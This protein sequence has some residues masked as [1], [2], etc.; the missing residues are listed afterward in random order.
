MTSF[1]G[2]F[3][4]M[5]RANGVP[6]MITGTA[7]LR[8]GANFVLVIIITD[9]TVTAISTSEGTVF[10]AETAIGAYLRINSVF[11]IKG[12]L[13]ATSA[14]FQATSLN[15]QYGKGNYLDQEDC[16]FE[17]FCRDLCVSST[18]KVDMS[19]IPQKWSER[20]VQFLDV[21]GNSS[22]PFCMHR[23][24]SLPDTRK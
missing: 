11:Y 16:P 22:K 7:D 3:T 14:G 2:M 23:I 4:L 21:P 24:L 20:R 15:P 18:P 13:N 5:T 9:G 10:P 19:M 1:V 12:N 6:I 17:R 8:E